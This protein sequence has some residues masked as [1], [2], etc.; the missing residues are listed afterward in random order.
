MPSKNYSIVISSCALVSSWLLK[1][2]INIFI[3]INV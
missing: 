1:I 2:Q 3:L